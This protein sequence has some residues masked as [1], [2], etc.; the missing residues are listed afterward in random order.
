MNACL[1]D[2]NLGLLTSSHT[3][4]HLLPLFKS[5]GPSPFPPNG[6]FAPT[7]FH[8]NCIN[9][10]IKASIRTGMLCYVDCVMEKIA[11]TPGQHSS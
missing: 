4:T 9:D 6:T 1:L 11:S 5:T 8:L 7:D 3:D 10:K 2:Q